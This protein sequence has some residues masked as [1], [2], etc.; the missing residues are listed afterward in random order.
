MCFVCYANYARCVPELEFGLLWPFWPFWLAG[1]QEN[2]RNMKRKCFVFFVVFFSFLFFFCILFFVL[3]SS[4]SELDFPKPVLIIKGPGNTKTLR[5]DL[6]LLD[7]LPMSLALPVS[8]SKSLVSKSLKNLSCSNFQL[9]SPN[10]LAYILTCPELF[11]LK[12]LTEIL[13][14]QKSLSQSFPFKRTLLSYWYFTPYLT[15]YF[16]RTVRKAML[17]Q[18]QSF[19]WQERYAKV[20]GPASWGRCLA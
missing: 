12:L 17:C 9:L 19:A 3:L 15:A 14:L 18:R 10:R 13:Y 2:P 16:P 7:C 8:S 5:L 20:I 1:N 6:P 11:S 4:W